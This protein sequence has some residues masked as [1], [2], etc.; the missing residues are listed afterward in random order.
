MGYIIAIYSVTKFPFCD[1]L[2]VNHSSSVKIAN[3]NFYSQIC[4]SL[5]ASV[6]NLSIS[7][8]F[9][10]TCKFGINGTLVLEFLCKMKLKESPQE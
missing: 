4:S 1:S 8:Q 2:F 9:F 5:E 7:V 3:H 10:V 6:D